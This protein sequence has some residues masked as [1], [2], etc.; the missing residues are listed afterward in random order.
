MSNAGNI[1]VS[2]E[3]NGSTVLVRPVGE[4][5]LG[6]SVT[7]RQKL[8]EAQAG[9]PQKLIVDLAM[10]PYMDSS[11]VATLLESMQTARRTNHKLVL[12][13]LQQRVRSVFEI[14][15]LETVFTIAEDADKANSA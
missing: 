12:C 13:S 6:T 15:K 7:L 10:V 14:A 4:I 1:E 3:R 2:I 8:R 9:Q 5:D 11:G